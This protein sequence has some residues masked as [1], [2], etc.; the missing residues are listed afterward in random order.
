MQA[1][2][3][4]VDNKT[5]D[6]FHKELVRKGVIIITVKTIK[7]VFFM[8]QILIGKMWQIFV[9]HWVNGSKV[10]SILIKHMI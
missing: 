10:L 9:W 4:S 6:I 5:V 3:Y 1:I 2:V 7:E 8:K